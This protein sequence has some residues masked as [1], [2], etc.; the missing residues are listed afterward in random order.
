MN[1]TTHTLDDII[2]RQRRRMQELRDD[3]QSLAE[4]VAD[5]AW[6][7]F[8]VDLD[9]IIGDSYLND[10]AAAMR[11]ALTHCLSQHYNDAFDH[12]VLRLFARMSE[13]LQAAL[14]ADGHG[15]D[16][17]RLDLA[18][19]RKSLRLIG[20]VEPLISEALDRARPG[21][22]DQI[23]TVLGS[24]FRDEDEEMDALTRDMEK[25]AA[26]V[27]REL[28]NLRAAIK[29]RMTEDT[30]AVINTARLSYIDWLDTVAA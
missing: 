23:G 14:A 7:H 30:R 26:R 19:I 25:E 17:A 28:R 24:L 12:H 18:G 10:M 5:E 6:D 27:K 21:V 1:A 22:A 9:T 3:A 20:H 16:I 2:A 11:M 15:Y 4:A 29:E 8:D 13:E